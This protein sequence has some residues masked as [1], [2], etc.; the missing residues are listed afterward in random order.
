M[1]R[2]D[3]EDGDI[4]SSLLA[5]ENL[6]TNGVSSSRN[7]AANSGGAA[8][9]MVVFSTFIAVCGSYVFG[10]AI[11]YSSP[12]MSGIMEDLGISLA[13]FSVFGSVMTIGAM[14]GA[15]FSGKIADLLGCR[16]AMGLSEISCVVGW[17]AIMFSKGAWSLD[18]GRLLIGCGVG[19]LSYVVPV[20][21]AEITP[22][23]LRGGFTTAHQFMLSVGLALTYFIGTVVNWRTLALIG[24]IPSLVQLVGL[25]FIPESPRWLV[26][27][28][29]EKDYEASLR[30]LRGEDADIFQEA[31]EIREYTEALQQL[32]QGRFLDLFQRIYAH[33]LIVGVGIMILQ[34]F[35][36]AN[37]IVFY[38]SSI[39]KL[40]GF[41]T[42]VGTTAMAV[43]QIPTSILSVIIMDKAGRKPLLMVSAVG[44]CLGCLITGLS[45]LL[46][47]YQ[48]WKEVTP[49][50]VFVGT[51]VYNG[52]F[53]L[54]LAG[55]PWLIMSEIF[56]INM[57]GSAGSLVSLVNW[58]SSWIVSYIFNFLMEWSSAGTFFIFASISGLTV[59][60]VAKLVPETKGQTLEEIQTTMNPR[61]TR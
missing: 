31:T 15:T 24:T 61:S 19:V 6:D 27:F 54:G 44:T 29:E 1:E 2:K 59:L 48:L 21:I 25:F 22:K 20:Y 10:A 3:I 36:G 43:A 50:L 26:K 42:E 9:A 39:F 4:T 14:L 28:G 53:G 40:A 32:P 11:G 8:T 38:A 17:L 57:K 16:W 60:F 37:G 12:A 7:V 23:R 56:P 33:S 52:S 47:D 18:L 34:Q 46:Q 35:G 49:V 55:I 58:F 13:Q 41:S 5:K 30:H 51:L 45:F